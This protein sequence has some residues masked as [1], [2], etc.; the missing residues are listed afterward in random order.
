[1]AVSLAGNIFI[2]QLYTLVSSKWSMYLYESRFTPESQ[3]YI[4][5]FFLKKRSAL[6]FG[7]A[8]TM[9]AGLIFTLSNNFRLFLLISVF[10]EVIPPIDGYFDSY[11][12]P[13]HFEDMIPT[14]VPYR[15]FHVYRL[16]LW[17]TLGPF[18]AA[19]LGHLLSGWIIFW[20]ITKYN[21]TESSAYKAGFAIFSFCG[22]LCFVLTLF[23]SDEVDQIPYCVPHSRFVN[24]PFL[25]LDTIE[26]SFSSN[27]RR[28]LNVNHPNTSR[29]SQ[30]LES[31]SLLSASP[32]TSI[33][34]HEVAYGTISPGSPSPTLPSRILLKPPHHKES[35]S[36]AVVLVKIFIAYISAISSVDSFASSL[37]ATPWISYY[38]SEKFKLDTPLLGS[39]FFMTTVLG[40][41]ATLFSRPL[42]LRLGPTLAFAL[43]HFPA[44][45]F[46]M[47]FP[48]SS[49]FST[50]FTF[51][52]LW[53]FIRHMDSIPRQYLIDRAF[54]GDD[55]GD[56]VGNG[57]DDDGV[58]H[59][60]HE[61]NSCF[62][63]Q[64][65]PTH[66]QIQTHAQ[67]E[68]QQR[69]RYQDDEQ[70][71]QYQELGQIE[72]QHPQS[73]KDAKSAYLNTISLARMWAET[74]G[75]LVSGYLASNGM[76]FETFILAGFLKII[77]DFAVLI[78]AAIKNLIRSRR[79]TRNLTSV[80]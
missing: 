49:I 31:S 13:Q 23:L 67:Q 6:Q 5:S 60:I 55:V 11:I 63:S 74:L 17:H 40:A 78:T 8:S 25:S 57:S 76:L 24:K 72:D 27:N 7:A 18:F 48:I 33:D 70:H 68:Y 69:Y 52:M 22:A 9:V 15:S 75:P 54:P 19:A 4:V 62:D 21:F 26:S 41:L 3:S 28:P 80:E 64:Q 66:E 46:L 38:L 56:S 58:H 50:S 16:Y 20:F 42:T 77:Y 39:A 79:Q 14:Y 43:S 29:T 65:L 51:L 32:H 12:A 45:L 47:A 73:N 71:R 2:S 53:G 10:G 37:V 34:E 59:E 30:D 44:S 1:M 36:R 61:Y 35:N